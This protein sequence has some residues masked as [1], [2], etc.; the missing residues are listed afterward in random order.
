M[1]DRIPTDDLYARLDVAAD[2]DGATIDRAWRR[3]LKRHHPDVAGTVSLEIAKRINVAHD[4]LSRPEL[5]LRYDT[6]RR[7]REAGVGAVTGP[8]TATSRETARS[9]AP[10]RRHDP[11]AAS[12]PAERSRA[13][14]PDDLDV[15]FGALAGAARE[16]LARAAALTVD[17]LDR[18]AV[19]DPQSFPA[20]LRSLVP[21][22]LWR[23]VTVLEDRLAARLGHA[24]WSDPRTAGSIGGLAQ[25][26]VLEPFLLHQL[27][28]AEDLLEHLRRGWESAVNQPRYGPNSRG[29]RLLIDRF[30]RATVAEARALAAG[31]AAVGGDVQPWPAHARPEDYAAL[32]VS[33]A[34]ARR[35]AAAVVRLPGV[36]VQE[37]LR[38][39]GAFARTAH[40][41]AL[42]PIY[43]AREFAPYHRVWDGV[44]RPWRGAVSE[45]P[46]DPTVRRA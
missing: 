32:Q 44:V 11:M 12:R 42:R 30:E 20:A 34:L 3:Q 16:L 38:L 22:E 33:A 4:W 1:P 2:A 24:A 17:D 8:G 41:T 27:D 45:A 13:A 21:P 37:E 15:I 46:V 6:A 19:S 43:P 29:V 9:P 28:D 36:D 5:R 25:A 31:W 35:D 18:L 23:R 7:I 26:T 10:R 39:R 14:P 40:I